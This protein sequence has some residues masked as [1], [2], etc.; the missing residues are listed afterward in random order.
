MLL[1]NLP[2]NEFAEMLCLPSFHTGKGN[3]QNEKKIKKGKLFYIVGICFAISS[4]D[5]QSFH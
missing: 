2:K 3:Q 1:K 4:T 5:C